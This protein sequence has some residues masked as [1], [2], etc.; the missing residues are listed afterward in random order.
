MQRGHV[1]MHG[2]VGSAEEAQGVATELGK[3]ACIHAA[4]IGKITQVVNSDR[5]KYVLEFE[6]KC[7]SEG[8]K[9]KPGSKGEKSEKAA[10]SGSADETED[11]AE[12]EEEP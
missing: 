5:Q 11:G 10:E 1:K 8:G 6:V 4:K 2:I 7:P 9:K 12:E 3:N